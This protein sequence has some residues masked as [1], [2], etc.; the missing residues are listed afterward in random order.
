M[1]GFQVVSRK[2]GKKAFV[3]KLNRSENKQ[4]PPENI[5]ETTTIRRVITTRSFEFPLLTFRIFSIIC[6]IHT[7]LKHESTKMALVGLSSET[8]YIYIYVIFCWFL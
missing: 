7:Y 3:A 1:D 6:T 5:S 8:S 2:K 4:Q